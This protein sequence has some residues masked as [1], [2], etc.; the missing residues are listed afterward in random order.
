MKKL[1]II[2]IA[3]ILV[4]SSCNNI[5]ENK[6]APQNN[7]TWNVDSNTSSWQATDTSTG[8]I[9]PITVIK[10]EN[11]N[12][13][14]SDSRFNYE[15]SYP[16]TWEQKNLEWVIDFA[17]V[18]PL[19][20]TWDIF[21]E[22]VNFLSQD[23]S[24]LWTFDEFYKENVKQIESGF[25]EF[26]ISIKSQED[27]TIPAW[28]AKKIIYTFDTNWTIIQTTQYFI[29][30]NSIAYLITIAN[31]AKNPDLFKDDIKMIVDSFK[32]KN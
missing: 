7:S 29:D 6:D 18:S 24:I 12:N 16:S 17:L 13:K 20:W 8:E 25:K 15:V 1:T 28:K 10:D 19:S 3:L 14:V 21:T 9:A 30:H 26:N 2:W 4:L 27:V 23:Y 11:W 31:E 32:F 22:N 5:F